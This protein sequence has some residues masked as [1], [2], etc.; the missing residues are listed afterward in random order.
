M[1]TTFR[2]QRTTP[3][4]KSRH[5]LGTLDT[6]LSQSTT[7]LIIAPTPTLR[8]ALAELLA[9]HTL[10]GTWI[11]I[12][13]RMSTMTELWQPPPSWHRLPLPR[14]LGTSLTVLCT[15]RSSNRTGLRA[16]SKRH[17][18]L[19]TTLSHRPSFLA[20]CRLPSRHIPRLTE[21]AKGRAMSPIQS[22]YQSFLQMPLPSSSQRSEHCRLF[23]LST[24]VHTM[25]MTGIRCSE[26]H[27]LVHI[28]SER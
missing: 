14:C 23:C 5:I 12:G 6:A 11:P 10:P 15:S 27:R 24:R 19:T 4:A 2:S 7:G 25:S 1:S 9:L 17:Q 28:R 8:Q 3:P 21:E 22:R 20:E 18:I 16:N 13:A 26:T